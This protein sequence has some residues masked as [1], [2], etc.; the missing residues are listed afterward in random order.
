MIIISNNHT[1]NTSSCS[2]YTVSYPPWDIAIIPRTHRAVV[3]FTNKKI[4]FINLQTFTQDDKLITIPNST[5]IYGITATSDNII[6]GDTRR[7]H[8]LD[9]EGIYLRTI[10][11]STES[12]THHLS[13]GHNNQI[14]YT[15]RSSINCVNWDGTEVFSYTIPNEESHKKIAIDR[16]YSQ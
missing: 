11:L 2:L 15:N 8:C 13:I 4:Q 14:Y 5:A 1:C 3:T 12:I 10:T 9:I 6:V 16:F 7:I